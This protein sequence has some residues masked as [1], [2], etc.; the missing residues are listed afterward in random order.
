MACVHQICV[1]ASRWRSSQSCKSFNEINPARDDQK[2]VCGEHRIGP[3]TGE[4]LA[5]SFDAHDRPRR[6]STGWLI[7]PASCW[8]SRR[9]RA[10]WR[11]RNHRRIRYNRSC[12]QYHVRDPLAH[13]RFGIGDMVRAGPLQDATVAFVGGYCHIVGTPRST[14]AEVV[15]TLASTS[16]PMPTTALA[17]SHAPSWRSVLTSVVSA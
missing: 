14:N 5:P 9:A 1:L 11:S 12:A 4:I 7:R 8:P 10:S 2:I 13:R 3:G 16:L 17:K 15:I 6:G